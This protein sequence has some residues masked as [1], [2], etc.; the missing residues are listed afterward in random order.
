MEKSRLFDLEFSSGNLNDF[1]CEFNEVIKTNKKVHV[2]TVNVDHVVIA[3][4]ENTFK[5]I[6]NRAD[7]VTA[8]GM[9]IVWYS[10][11]IKKALP[12]RITGADISEEFCKRSNDFGYKMFFLGAA[13]GIAE[14]AK[15]EMEKKYKNPAIVGTYSPTRKELESNKMNKEIIKKI[16]ESN[17]NVLLVAL[18]APKQEEW[19]SANLK[20]LETNINIGIGATLDFMANKVKRS[21]LIL[22]KLGLEWAYRM[23]NEPK[24]LFKRYIIQDS[25]FILI[26]LKDLKIR[27]NK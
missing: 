4:K 8:D 1:F 24:R 9:P 10:K 14:L 3:H 2:H 16:N 23:L 25:Y 22:Q 27:L 20:Y 6:V 12:E 15:K 7:F 11:I 5:D 13:P 21:P 26:L 17:A 19:I 18:G